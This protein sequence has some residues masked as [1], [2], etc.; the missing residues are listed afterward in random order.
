MVSCVGT[1]AY[2]RVPG[3]S[4]V[5]GL[6]SH[7]DRG[8]A[9]GALLDWSR[10]TATKPSA[11]Y[12]FTGDPIDEGAARIGGLGRHL[13]QECTNRPRS[14]GSFVGWICTDPRSRGTDMGQVILEVDT[15]S[16]RRLDC[17]PVRRSRV[18]VWLNQEG[19]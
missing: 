1:A 4:N 15:T 2:G 6:P 11:G 7:R 19:S 17:P 12:W 3:A 10:T 13:A 14:V 9:P 16:A 5:D 18:L 8:R